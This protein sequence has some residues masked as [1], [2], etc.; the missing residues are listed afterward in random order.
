MKMTESRGIPATYMTTSLFHLIQN[1]GFRAN[2]MT[3]ARRTVMDHSLM[4][5]AEQYTSENNRPGRTAM[6]YL[7][8]YVLNTTDYPDK[9][10][11]EYT[12]LAH[13]TAL[14]MAERALT[15]PLTEWE[16]NPLPL[17]YHDTM[18][19]VGNGRYI[20]VSA[21]S[22]PEAQQKFN[23]I[24]MMN[25]GS[26]LGPDLKR[27]GTNDRL[28]FYG[29]FGDGLPLIPPT[30]EL[31][32]EML[33]GSERGKY[34]NDVL[35]WHKFSGGAITV[36]K[37][38]INA[39]MAGAKPEHLPLLLAAAEI[40]ANGS[41]ND[42]MWYHGM[43]TGSD[44]TLHVMINGPLGRELGIS[45]AGGSSG[46]AN[47]E[48]NNI[49]G[50]AVRMLH[51]NLGHIILE[52]DDHQYKGREHD[53]VMIFFREQEEL[54]PGWDP[55]NW[56]GTARPA[57]MWAPYHVEMGFRPEESTIT[58]W[59]GNSTGGVK[60]GEPAFW[61]TATFSGIGL[62]M[63]INFGQFTIPGDINDNSVDFIAISP[64]MAQAM[65]DYRNI[66]NKDQL[67][68]TAP[69]PSAPAGGR[70][71][72][73]NPIVSGG[74][75]APV[76]FY[77]GYSFYDR[78]NHQIQLISGATKT[79]A[80]RS[81]S[82][83]TADNHVGVVGDA[84][85]E[86]GVPIASL[87]PPTIPVTK[88]NGAWMPSSVR[89]LQVKYAPAEALRKINAT[90]SWD[91][92]ADDGN[93]PIIAYQIAFAH[94]GAIQF[95]AVT[96]AS[97]GRVNL[98]DPFSLNYVP[99]RYSMYNHFTVPFMEGLDMG[100]Q[101]SGAN[102]IYTITAGTQAF[103]NRS[104]T[105]ENLPVGYE[106]F[107]RVRA[108]SGVRNA[109]EIDAT[110]WVSTAMGGAKTTFWLNDGLTARASGRGAWGLY[111]GGRSNIISEAIKITGVAPN[112][113]GQQANV[114]FPI[115]SANGKGYT[116][117]ISNTGE[118]GTFSAYGNVNFNAKGAHIKGLAKGGT[119]YIYIMYES[120]GIAERSDVVLLI[121]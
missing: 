12:G 107:F 8:Q 38:A 34:P 35:G 86:A 56:D 91:K 94:S 45:G 50:R 2:G 1:Q 19:G 71:V 73:T 118:E 85:D 67:R 121:L 52:V 11:M 100:I 81:A 55:E 101:S 26:G 27:V 43:G 82:V 117:Y 72:S 88:P 106:V 75:L 68:A 80:G 116:V 99:E 22:Y 57:D 96:N 95:F 9:K 79:N 119:Y 98:G 7:K 66:K 23:Q 46:G 102:R 58:I 37:V 41:D 97:A 39:V 63:P 28:G 4:A 64:G 25:G 115:R 114:D 40:F 74:D 51:R 69:T 21:D 3:N 16:R 31:V 109:F 13:L 47:N 92:P 36:E 90:L 83:F 84:V 24:A 103:N 17:T 104:F 20:A 5:K 76:R 110:E 60:G 61:S 62:S 44:S 78:M 18:L 32:A 113:N 65:Y 108:I 15:A 42:K 112:G 59:A 29:N 89:N 54:L 105:F 120:N 10:R 49:I 33:A 70:N 93:S 77:G 48:A 14:E 6:N 53:H 111:D 87:N 30:D